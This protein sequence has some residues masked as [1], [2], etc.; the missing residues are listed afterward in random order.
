MAPGDVPTVITEPSAFTAVAD[1][2]S[3]PAY[4]RLVQVPP[5]YVQMLAPPST[6]SAVDPSRL[7]ET[8]VQF[9]APGVGVCGVHVVALST[10]T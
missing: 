5:L 3:V 1:Q 2:G 8:E 4:V 6:A 7:T 9:P 10:E